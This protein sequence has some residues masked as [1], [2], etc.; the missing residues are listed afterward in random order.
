MITIDQNTV[1]GDFNFV[2]AVHRRMIIDALLFEAIEELSA[3]GL[4]VL[5]SGGFQ[6]EIETMKLKN[7]VN[8]SLTEYDFRTNDE[9][10]KLENLSF[11]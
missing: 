8:S 6:T 9:K 4:V 1:E 3:T 5:Q 2:G 10:Y 11:I 7:K